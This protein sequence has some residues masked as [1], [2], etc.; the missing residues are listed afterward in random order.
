MRIGFVVTDIQD[1]HLYAFLVDL[2]IDK[3]HDVKLYYN[4]V[5][6]KVTS[7]K[8]NIKLVKQYKCSY[9]SYSDMKDCIKKVSDRD[10]VFTNEGMPFEYVNLPFK[11]IALSWATE[12]YV[13]GKRFLNICDSFFCD[14]SYDVL[15]DAFDFSKYKCKVIYDKH[16]KYYIL[17]NKTRK[18]VCDILGLD[19][20]PKYV[21][22]LGPAPAQDYKPR[23]KEIRKLVDFFKNNGY[24]IIYKQKPKCPDLVNICYYDIEMFHKHKKYSTS[25]LLTYISDFVVAF[26]SSGVVESIRTDT[27]FVNLFIGHSVVDYRKH[28]V[29]LLNYDKIL[30]IDSFKNND[31]LKQFFELNKNCIKRTDYDIAQEIDF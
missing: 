13:H 22:V 17:Q 18:D 27:P 7:P 28:P 25:L 2:Y 15:K 6:K 8:K 20:N 23:L 12:A 4:S 11:M 29:S 31:K 26:N 16:P 10:I 5:L 3:K 1:F 24:K 14:C 21:T 19:E 30:R 9:D